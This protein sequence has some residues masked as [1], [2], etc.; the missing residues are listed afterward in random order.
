MHTK[1]DTL[2]GRRF[3]HDE[4][5]EIVAC[6]KW[7]LNQASPDSDVRHHSR[8]SRLCHLTT[9][10]DVRHHSRA[11]RD[12]CETSPAQNFDGLPEPSERAKL[13]LLY[14]NRK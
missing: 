7:P 1:S 6:A 14:G 10:N 11:S 5:G 4:I 9:E 8:A 12:V 3:L 2:Q 13:G